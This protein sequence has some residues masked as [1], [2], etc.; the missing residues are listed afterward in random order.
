MKIEYHVM[1][2]TPDGPKVLDFGFAQFAKFPTESEAEKA[3]GSFFEKEKS[4]HKFYIRKMYVQDKK[5]K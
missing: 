3:I 1:Y 2:D 4:S 5:R